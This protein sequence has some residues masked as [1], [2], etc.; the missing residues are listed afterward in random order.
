MPLAAAINQPRLPGARQLFIE[1]L[2]SRTLLSGTFTQ[3]VITGNQAPVSGTGTMLL[4]TDGTVMMQDGGSENGAPG[5]VT[6]L[7][8]RLTPSAT[9]SYLNGTWSQLA[10]MSYQRYDYAA[11]VLPSGQV[12]IQGGEVSTDYQYIPPQ[13]GNPGDDTPS[14]EVYNPLTNTW[15]NIATFA[16]T[17]TDG[18]DNFGDDPTE[19][20]PNGNVLGGY[21][22]GPQTYVYNPTANTWTQTGT[23]LTNDGSDEEGFVLL[24]G[25]NVLSYDIYAPPINGMWQAQYYNASTGTWKATGGVPVPLSQATYTYPDGKVASDLELGPPMLLPDGRVFWLGANGNTAFYTPSTNT[26]TA[27]PVIPDSLICDDAPAAELPDGNI[28]FVAEPGLY[29]GPS[30]LLEFNPTTNT[31]TDLSSQLPTSFL[32]FGLDPGRGVGPG[33]ESVWYDYPSYA[34]RMLVLPTGQVMIGNTYD[35]DLFV[36]TDQAGTAP[37]PAAVPTISSIAPEGSGAFLLTGTGLNG[38]SEGAA[39][40]DDAEMSSNYPIVELTDPSGNVYDARTY[41]WA[42]GVATGSALVTTNFALPAGLPTNTYMVTVIANGVASSPMSLTIAG[43]GTDPAPTVA[44]PAAATPSPVAGTTTALS[45]LGADTL[46]ESTLTYTWTVAILPVGAATPTFA[47]NGSNAAKNDTVTFFAAGTYSFQATFANQAGLSTSSS[48]TVIVK[49]TVSV[50]SLGPTAVNVNRNAT[51][52]FTA[53]AKDQFGATLT[54]QPSFI[55]TVTPGGGG[56]SASGLYTAP[57]TGT[58][59]TVSATSGLVSSNASVFVLSSPYATQDVGSVAISGLAGDNGNGTFVV[60]GSGAGIGGTADAF[61]FAYQ[62]LSGNG[63]ITA[64]FDSQQ[65]TGTSGLAGL[66]IRNGLTAGATMAFMGL[67]AGGSAEFEART[68][69]S[70]GA[71]S[72]SSSLKP[73]WIRLVRSGTTFTGF[74]SL[75]GVTW[76]LLGSATIAMGTTVDIGIG[77]TGESDGTLDTATFGQISIDQT[78]TVATAAAAGPLTGTSVSLSVLGADLAG[79]STLT[80]SLDDHRAPLTVP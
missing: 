62:T 59:A 4:L 5:D 71:S 64:H 34:Y 6:N 61:R 65:I 19:L 69:T 1:S 18:Y 73:S 17:G 44:S 31:Y 50:I 29:E 10:S 54:A 14:G 16:P 9:G 76:T 43:S 22:F 68:T 23:K 49:P 67:L 8:Y 38:I 30:H 45:V 72:T 39:Y 52:Q 41:N 70:G 60:T 77:A 58:L 11:E 47:I 36:F 80:Y 56:L 24:P 35:D 46:G 2:E 3:L 20:L 42:P 55:W 63:A 25:G 74:D 53:T 27:G 78:P 51:Q 28:L 33:G 7:W 21:I 12:M 15:T 13:G 37:A 79:E 75:D 57:G 32:N 48:V 40:G 26:W 66:M